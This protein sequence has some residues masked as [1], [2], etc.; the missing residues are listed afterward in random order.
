[1]KPSREMLRGARDRC[2]GGPVLRGAVHAD[3][4]GWGRF[5]RDDGEKRPEEQGFFKRGGGAGAED[6]EDDAVQSYSLLVMN[7]DKAAVAPEEVRRRAREGGRAGRE[8]D[9]AVRGGF[10]YQYRMQGAVSASDSFLGPGRYAVVDLSAG[11]SEFGSMAAG[12]GAVIA[13]TL[14]RSW[15][16]W[17]TPLGPNSAGRSWRF[18]AQIIDVVR[19]AVANVFVP[20]LAI[21]QADYSEEVLVA[22]I[23][24]RDHRNFDP[25]EPGHAF[26]LDV[27]TIEEQVMLLA[28][29]EQPVHF[30]AGLHNLQEHERV[31][32]AV[33]RASRADTSHTHREGRV[34]SSYSHY[35]DSKV[36]LS[37]LAACS[38]YLA[39]GLMAGHPERHNFF[40]EDKAD[41]KSKRKRGITHQGRRVLPVYVLSLQQ[42]SEA[43]LIDGSG[44]YAA[45]KEAVVVLQHGD[46][47]A[48]PFFSARERLF[49]SATAPTS[50]VIAGVVTALASVAPPSQRYSQKHGAVQTD[51]L[52][53]H[54]YSPYAP[55]A[56]SSQLSQA[57]TSPGP[58]REGSCLLESS[59]CPLL[60]P[61]RSLI[62]PETGGGGGGEA[63]RRA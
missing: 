6:P 40:P 58:S 20:D 31:A 33:A 9:D 49:V 3:G 42:P 44:L 4:L 13:Q 1:M 54:G 11:P 28:L 51:F 29:P 48:A 62:P 56:S 45:S 22:L 15:F 16:D 32:I 39:A 5:K 46:V 63:V 52:W 19:S 17:S 47:V 57:R 14:P 61:R 53:A 7:I 23:V 12:G 41:D 38:D 59:G 43:L 26:S 55:F 8:A 30:V 2:L 24:L 27:A 35:I 36:L 50:S 60:R 37:E 10:M 18:Q 21:D 25:L 34:Q